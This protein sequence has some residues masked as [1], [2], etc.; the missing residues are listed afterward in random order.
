MFLLLS[1]ELYYIEAENTMREFLWGCFNMSTQKFYY[2]II[3][4]CFF[5]TTSTYAQTSSSP[6]RLENPLRLSPDRLPITDENVHDLSLL[7][8]WGMGQLNSAIWL[9]DNDIAVVSSGGTWLYD[10]TQP[11]TPYAVI[12]SLK[13]TGTRAVQ[14]LLSPDGQWLA[15]QPNFSNYA[16]NRFDFEVWHVPTGTHLEINPPGSF[17]SSNT[18]YQ[19]GR[20]G[21][22]I[23]WLTD[24]RF[25][26]ARGDTIAILELSVDG[27]EISATFTHDPSERTTYTISQVAISPDNRWLASITRSDISDQVIVQLWDIE[28]GERRVLHED[29]ILPEQPLQGGQIQFNADSSELSMLIGVRAS[30]QS[31][32]TT[33]EI[34]RWTVDSGESLELYTLADGCHAFEMLNEHHAILCHDSSGSTSS[35]AIQIN[36]MRDNTALYDS[37]LLDRFLAAGTDRLSDSFINQGSLVA[38]AHNPNEQSAPNTVPNNI[39]IWDL[40]SRDVISLDA[41]LDRITHISINPSGDKV[42]ALQSDQV[43]IIDI[44]TNTLI[45]KIDQTGLQS[46]TGLAVSPD[47][48]RLISVGAYP[49]YNPYTVETQTR[50]LYWD[51]LTGAFE[52][53]PNQTDA[54]SAAY[55]P[56]GTQFALGGY[57]GNIQLYSAETLT[58]QN[59]LFNDGNIAQMTYSNDGRMLVTANGH[60][61]RFWD[62]QELTIV[63]RLAGGYA[64]SPLLFTPDDEWLVMGTGILDVEDNGRLVAVWTSIDADERQQIINDAYGQ[65]TTIYQYIAQTGIRFVESASVVYTDDLIIVGAYDGVLYLFGVSGEANR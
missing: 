64:R 44:A 55:N 40:Q 53:L 39:L 1:Q 54:I 34:W 19:D 46:I 60:Y 23:G 62:M 52:I 65:R 6:D 27:A 22:F 8:I 51:L 11:D 41:D 58:R 24:S 7:A 57:D 43:Q 21:T 50:T 33:V 29:D 28:T 15:V 17:T 20:I 47:G 49:T 10:I 16:E 37:V 2:L 4:L 63:N 14:F 9:N 13:T 48:H 26:I 31:Y 30:T 12:P 59:V 5:V 25:V 18:L 56:D 3:L 36:D 61:F 38:V 45:T 42:A 35:Y 32:D